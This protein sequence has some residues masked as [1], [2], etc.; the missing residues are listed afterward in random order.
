MVILYPVLLR[1]K[2]IIWPLT[3]RSAASTAFLPM[4]TDSRMSAPDAMCEAHR[5]EVLNS[6]AR[7]LQ[8]SSARRAVQRQVPVPESCVCPKASVFA[9]GS[10][11]QM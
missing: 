3:P 11:S 1:M 6:T 9:P 10:P 5:C 8:P 4:A 2:F 7:V